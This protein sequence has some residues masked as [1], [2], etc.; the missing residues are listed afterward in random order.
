MTTLEELKI[1]TQEAIEAKIDELKRRL[2]ETE[3]KLENNR[4][5]LR[6]AL[7]D[8]LSE[9]RSTYQ[10]TVAEARES[11]K[12][13]DEVAELWKQ[14][15]VFYSFWLKWWEEVNASSNLAEEPVFIYLGELLKKLE[16]ASAQAYEFHA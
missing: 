8:L 14:A 3:T 7:L 6:D 16:R 1:S 4:K 5:E 11:E 10:I 9:V 2:F 12:S 13:V 15:S